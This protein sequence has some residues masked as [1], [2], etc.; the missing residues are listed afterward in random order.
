LIRASYWTGV[1]TLNG[2]L[3][4]EALVLWWNDTSARAMAQEYR[5]WTT[6]LFDAASVNALD[7]G[8]LK[9]GDLAVTASGVHV[10]VFAG[11]KE[12][13]EADPGAGRVIRVRVPVERNGWFEQPVRIVRWTRLEGAD[14]R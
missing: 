1:S 6:H 5:G 13:I 11:G 4:R 14:G 2:R 3:T 9:P 8:R 10:M 7:C 12:W